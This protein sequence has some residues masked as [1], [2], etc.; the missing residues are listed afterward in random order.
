MIKNQYIRVTKIVRPKGLDIKGLG[1][2]LLK[3]AIYGVLNS[4]VVQDLG[5]SLSERF[6][7]FYLLSS[8]R[9]ISV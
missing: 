3:D 6:L 2:V 5:V 1:L 8:P 4:S 7:H 9:R